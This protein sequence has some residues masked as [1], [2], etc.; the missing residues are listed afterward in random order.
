M[1]EMAKV[2][3]KSLDRISVLPQDTIE[4]ILTHMPIRDALRTSILSKKWRHYWKGMPKL[5]FDDEYLKGMP[6]LVYDTPFS[7]TSSSSKE[8]ISLSMPSSMFC[9]YTMVILEFSISINTDAKIVDEIDQ[10]IFHLSKSKNIKKF[11]FKFWSKYNFSLEYVKRYKLPS[12][13]F[14][15]QGLEHLHLT[16]CVIE[17]PLT[18]DG[19]ITLRSLELFD[20]N[21]TAQTLQQILTNCPILEEFILMG[22]QN[23]STTQGDKCT[24]LELSER[25]PLVQVLKISKS[26]IKQ[27]V[28]TNDMKKLLTSLVHLRIL[29]F[30]VCFQKEDGL[31]YALNVIS[32]SPNLE[33]IK[34]ELCLNH[35]LCGE[36]TCNDLLDLQD[37]SGINLDHLEELEITN[38]GNYDPEMEFLKLIMAKSPLLKKARIKLSK[39]VSVDKEVKMLRDLLRLTF[40]R[41]S[42]A[43]DIIIER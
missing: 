15:L 17:L 22:C 40:P 4:N 32:S 11:I 5:V 3:C 6:K 43:V 37:Y 2:Q 38:F 42:P 41:A 16:H 24:F 13:F 25:L 33:K 34:I 14:S 10:I 8:N 1:E 12:M 7:Y 27:H 36:E 28:T 20:A 9:C 23:D 21:I 29:C 35:E 39:S 26:Y 30:D 31:S 18:F 19:F